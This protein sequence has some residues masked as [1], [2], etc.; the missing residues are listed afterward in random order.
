MRAKKQ[1]G[2]MLEQAFRDDLRVILDGNKIE[3]CLQCGTCTASCPVSYLMDYGP[4]KLVALCRNG[5]LEEVLRSNTPW[6]CVS[7]YLCTTR[8]PAGIRITDLLYEIKRL[9]KKS[10]INQPTNGYEVLSEKF[11][12]QVEKY[13]RVNE[14]RLTMSLILKNLSRMFDTVP[15]GLKLLRKGRISLTSI[16][17]SES[18]KNIKDLTQISERIKLRGSG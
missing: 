11:I 13:G 1:E 14:M 12:E 16:I 3:A 8:C 6:M 9:A 2:L 7:C 10:G 4:R 17:K 18:I 5:M 15:L